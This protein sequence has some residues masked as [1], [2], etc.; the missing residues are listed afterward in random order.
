MAS[1]TYYGACFCMNFSTFPC[2]IGHVHYVHGN[3][4][5]ILF[6]LNSFCIMMSNLINLLF[7]ILCFAL[8][9]CYFKAETPHCFSSPFIESM[10]PACTTG[11]LEK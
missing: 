1:N 6:C 2:K 7:M 10:F 5:D 9:L 4:D 8:L 11:N 3:S